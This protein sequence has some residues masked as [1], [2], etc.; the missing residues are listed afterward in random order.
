MCKPS[1]ARIVHWDPWKLWATPETPPAAH[2]TLE[3]DH[4]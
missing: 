4:A 1:D 3:K 2:I